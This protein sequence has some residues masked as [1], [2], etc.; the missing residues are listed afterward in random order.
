[1]FDK[2]TGM[3]ATKTSPTASAVEAAD[4]TVATQSAMRFDLLPSERVYGSVHFLTGGTGLREVIAIKHAMHRFPLTLEFH[5]TANGKEH[6]L[7]GVPVT[8]RVLT[9]PVVLKTLSAG[10]FLLARLRPGQYAVTAE[11]HGQVQ[12]QEVD[13]HANGGER[14]VFAWDID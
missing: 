1:M 13:V 5:T 6:L 8:I 3:S 7:S 12:T 4:G 2:E 11:Y 9:G 10:P 14:L